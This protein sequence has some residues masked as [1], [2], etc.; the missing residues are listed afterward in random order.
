[1]VLNFSKSS[2]SR[3]NVESTKIVFKAK[4]LPLRVGDG[5]AMFILMAI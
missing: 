3:S 5:P 4:G 2:Q 1:M